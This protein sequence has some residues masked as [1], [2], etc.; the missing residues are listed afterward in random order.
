MRF[1]SA[2]WLDRMAASMAPAPPEVSVAIHQRITGGPDGD[3]EYTIRLDGGAVVVEP[4]PGAADVEVVEDYETAAAISQGA[5]SPAAAFAA[6][7][8]RLGGPVRSLIEHQEA[9]ASVGV[10]MTALAA[11]TVY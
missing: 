11:A 6:G 2:E 7:R 4:G 10:H 1:L 8:L 3:V 9:L 5:L